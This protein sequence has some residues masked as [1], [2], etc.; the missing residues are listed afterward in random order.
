MNFYR[1]IF[2]YNIILLKLYIYKLNECIFENYS[3]FKILNGSILRREIVDIIQI[4]RKI[5]TIK[6]T[7]NKIADES[8]W[9]E[10]RKGLTFSKFLKKLLTGLYNAPIEIPTMIAVAKT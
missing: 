1:V 4:K 9:I 3:S 10:N 7:D 5:I 8:I 2:S 6:V